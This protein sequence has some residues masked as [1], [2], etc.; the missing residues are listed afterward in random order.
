M[1]IPASIRQIYENQRAVCLR[2]KATV[3]DKMT[4]LKEPRWH[5]ESRVK[6]LPSF[7]LKVETGRFVRPEALEDF[8]ACTLVVANLS[9]LVQAEQMVCNQFA[10]KNRRPRAAST[11]AKSSDAF[12][13]D[14]VRL[15]V[16]LASHAARPPADLM[17]IV[18][19]VQVKTFLQHA[20]SI[21]THDLI[22]KADD[23][24]WSMERIAYQVK[25]MLEHAE[26]AISEASALS[27]C[28]ALARSDER[29]QATREWIAFIRRHWGPDE[30][31][32]DLRRLAGNIAALA[33][34]LEVQLE[35][36]DNILTAKRAD[37][38]AAHPLNLSPYATLVQ[39]LMHAEKEKMIALLGRENSSFR[40]LVPEEVVLPDDID[41][42]QLRNAV[43][44]GEHW[45]RDGY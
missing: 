28:S 24:S 3:D 9:E 22:Y 11:T 42:R 17:D 30:L 43:L 15:Y 29:T 1:K 39:Y 2:L 21:A 16:T 33:R 35:R 10:L 44:V 6:A 26:V 4:A 38:G 12:P 45:A 13:F 14:D 32:D 37:A 20:W 41:L 25:A 18:F 31:P 36:L 5:Y 8:F 40:V 34:A 27:G 23:A 7:A 19:E